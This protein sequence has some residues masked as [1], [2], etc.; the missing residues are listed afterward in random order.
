M[1]ITLAEQHTLSTTAEFI[2]NIR[3][4]A[5]TVALEVLSEDPALLGGGNPR[6][7]V[8]RA[9][10]GFKTVQVAVAQYGSNALLGLFLTASS[11]LAA[12]TDTLHGV[13]HKTES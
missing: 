5:A 1:T 10:P 3:Q 13:V 12:A 2:N 4:A 8:A 7:R 6:D 11:F 9:E